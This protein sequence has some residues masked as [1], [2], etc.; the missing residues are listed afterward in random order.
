MACNINAFIVCDSFDYQ[1]FPFKNLN[2]WSLAPGGKSVF[3]GHLQFAAE[4][5]LS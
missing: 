2:D 3:Q 4:C 1:H 5:V